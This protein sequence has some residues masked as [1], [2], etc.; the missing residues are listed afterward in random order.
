MLSLNGNN[1]RKS[2]EY[3]LKSFTLYNAG[4]YDFSKLR[5]LA[6][7]DW[8]FFAL[9]L[10]GC[11][12][13]PHTIGGL[14]L[15]GKLKGA[16]VLV[17]NHLEHPGRRI[18]EETIESIHTAVGNKVGSKFFIIAPRNVFDFQQD[19]IPMGDVRYFALRIPYSIVHEL[20]SGFTALRQPAD[21][22]DINDTVDSVGFDFI[23]PPTVEWSVDIGVRNGQ[24]LREAFLEITE[25]R[26]KVRLRG[27]DTHGG[28]ET[29]S[30]LLLDFNYNG[31]V[32]NLDA[33]FYNHQ[34]EEQGWR[35]WFSY[36]SL[37]E[38]VMAVFMD[39]HG[40]ESQ[41]VIPRTQFD[42]QQ[43]LGQ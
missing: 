23:Q 25:F 1:G 26:S 7:K 27:E 32:F 16:S 2:Q 12:D 42:L 8:R 18:D 36:E 13:E 28:L 3:R 21:E 17:F 34:L 9:Q 6:W 40:N 5:Q 43:Q 41:V 15:D 31:D 20:H 29:F 24:L 33:V 30:M 14:K 35:A 39:I 38:Q 10:F 37:G 22:R 19:Y 4:L 11:R